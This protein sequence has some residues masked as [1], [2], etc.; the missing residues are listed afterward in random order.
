MNLHITE[1]L[2]SS[3][4]GDIGDFLSV[5]HWCKKGDLMMADKGS[6]PGAADVRERPNPWNGDSEQIRQK[7]LKVLKQKH[8]QLRIKKG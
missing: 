2:F 6:P 1:P 4:K 5:S 8:L 7:A 3:N